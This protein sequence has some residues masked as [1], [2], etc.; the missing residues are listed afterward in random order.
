MKKAMLLSIKNSMA[1]NDY[2][3]RLAPQFV[4]IRQPS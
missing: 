4:Q 3:Q 1:L 2:P